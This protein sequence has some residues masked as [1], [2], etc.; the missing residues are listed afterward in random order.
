MKRQHYILYAVAAVAVALLKSLLTR[1]S[2]TASLASLVSFGGIRPQQLRMLTFPLMWVMH[3][4]G[5][6]LPAAEVAID[7]IAC[8]GYLLL[9]SAI[10]SHFSAS[11]NRYAALLAILPLIVNYGVLGYV[12]YPSD[13][14]ALFLFT[15]AAYYILKDKFAMLCLVSVLAAFN[16]ETA[17]LIVPLF[18]LMNWRS[19]RL[20][21]ALTRASILIA[22]I[23][24]PLILLHFIFQ[25][26]PGAMSEDHL[27]WNISLLRQAFTF[28]RPGIVY[29]V[30]LF[31]GFH[32][33]SLLYLRNSPYLFKALFACSVLLVLALLPVSIYTEARVFNEANLGFTLPLLYGIF[34]LRRTSHEAS[35]KFA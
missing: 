10:L 35:R 22:A 34:A 12:S 4:L 9:V 11:I 13:L 8:F 5:I 25:S 14:M 16:R 29:A 27:S 15:A 33:F 17:V 6:S 3:Q 23:A 18:I 26:N 20:R 1:E 32:L 30:S 24:A 2:E 19:T 28:H 21:L 7:A 31:A